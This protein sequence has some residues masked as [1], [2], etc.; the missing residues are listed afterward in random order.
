[1]LWPIKKFPTRK[2]VKYTPGLLFIIEKGGGGQIVRFYERGTKD[3]FFKV[4]FLQGRPTVHYFVYCTFCLPSQS[5]TILKDIFLFSFLV[6]VPKI[7]EISLI[8]P[9]S[10]CA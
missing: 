1:L 5:T 9:A 6:I 4:L 3:R 10:L 7:V 8:F 2:V